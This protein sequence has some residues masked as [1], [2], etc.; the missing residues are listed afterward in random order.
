M[1]ERD[2]G[3]LGVMGWGLAAAE[4][5]SVVVVAA[6]AV[7]LRVGDLVKTRFLHDWVAEQRWWRDT[8]G[9]LLVI[10]LRFFLAFSKVGISVNN[11]LSRK[12]HLEIFAKLYI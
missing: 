4:N 5:S 12:I 6:V 3:S 10:A 8:T 2:I 1:A 11:L 9:I 7:P